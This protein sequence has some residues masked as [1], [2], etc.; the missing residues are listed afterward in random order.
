MDTPQMPAQIECGAKVEVK[1]PGNRRR[2]SGVVTRVF[3]NQLITQVE[4][5]SFFNGG[6]YMSPITDVRL[7]DR[8][9]KKEAEND[10]WLAKA[11]Q[12]RRKYKHPVKDLF[13]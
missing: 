4:F 5:R 10:K 11:S 13:D 2:L 9:L 8:A 12:S 6:T 7:Y 3:T 1:R